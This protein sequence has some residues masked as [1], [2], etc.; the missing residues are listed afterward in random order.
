MK[1]RGKTLAW[2][3]LFQCR[4]YFIFSAVTLYC[5]WFNLCLCQET[6]SYRT[7]ASGNFSTVSIWQ[8]YD[9]AI[10]T[11]ASVKPSQTNDIYID[12]NHKVTLT[13]NEEVKSLFINAETGAGEKFNIN[14]RNINIYGSLQAFSGAAPGSPSGTWNSQNWIGNSITSTL[15]FKGNSRIIIPKNAWSGFTTQSRYTVIFDP[16]P[17]VILTIEEPFKAVKFI[18]RSGTLHQKLDTSVMPNFCSSLSF[19]T[20]TSYYPPGAF[21]DFLIESNGK[22]ISECNENIIARSISGSVSALLFELQTGGE[23]ILEGTSPR[24]EAANFRMEGKVIFRGG[25]STKS[26]LAPTFADAGTLSSFHH[27]E[28]QGLQNVQFPSTL[29]ITGDLSRIG[30][31]QFLTNNSH[32]TFSGTA[33]Q[34]IVGFAFSPQDLTVNK[35]DGKLKLDQNMSVLRN[36]TMLDG[37]LD[38]QNNSLTINTSNSGVLNYQAGS[39]ENLSSFTYANVPIT[40]TATN[41]SFPFGDRYHGGIRK[42]Q[43][44]G[45][46]AGGNLTINYT[47]YKGADF[48]P[49]FNDLDGTP[50]LYRLF[51]YFNFSGLNTSTNPLELRISAQNLIVDEPE[52]LRLVCTGYAA[53][54]THIE[55]SDATNLW[56]IRNLTFDDLPGKNFTVGSFRTLS[57][58]P[59]TWLSLSVSFKENIKH[60]TWSVAGE[61]ENEKF[62]I[63]R[64]DSPLTKWEKIG[65]VPSQG[66]S[67]SPAFYSFSD[68]SLSTP[69]TTYYQIRLI[70]LSGQSSWSKVVRLD[71]LSGNINDQFSIFPNPHSSGSIRV[72]LPESYNAEN[73]QVF[74]YSTQGV[75]ISSFGYSE[76]KFTEELQLLKP[77]FYFVTFSNSVKS[78]QTR[79][80]KK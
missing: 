24:I 39:W 42:V 74:I 79:W 50:I 48:N 29:T 2:K 55:S 67:D 31:G 78:L 10:W 61:N 56:A 68:I 46:N 25:S 4:I 38:F 6:G 59:V 18:V 5:L 13:G 20:E 21:G 80:V 43:L 54:G 63:Y 69:V 57:I 62:E 76:I 19:N 41:G 70:D 16:G 3:A 9:G 53:P 12:K 8:I 40:F 22:F 23:L 35:S 72:I 51:S 28:I 1:T 27:I 64:S 30:S 73:T 26:I 45:I 47:E 33:D 34:E 32:L 60:I 75:L 58:L 77:G 71:K 17:G 36:L 37:K 52:D 65:E 66:N 15:T 14:G 11:A 49:S 7:I 44:L